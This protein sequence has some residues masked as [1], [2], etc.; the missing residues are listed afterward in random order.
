M[1]SVGR[2][3]KNI[4]LAIARPFV[5]GQ[6]DALVSS[7]E[8]WE[9][10]PLSENGCADYGNIGLV[11]SFSRQDEPNLYKDVHD[12]FETIKAF[13]DQTNGWGGC[14]SEVD[15]MFAGLSIEEDLYSDYDDKEEGEILWVNGPNRQVSYYFVQRL[16]PCKHM[17]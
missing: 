11:L 15:L 14:I 3:N 4:S 9:L 17:F 1:R 6:T 12:A 13:R 8:D 16:Q 10:F 7:F 5:Y 2:R